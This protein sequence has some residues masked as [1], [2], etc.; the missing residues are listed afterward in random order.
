[1]YVLG[2][3]RVHADSSINTEH[4]VEVSQ[5]SFSLRR[6]QRAGQSRTEFSIRRVEWHKVERVSHGVQYS[7]EY[8]FHM[9]VLC[10]E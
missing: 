10:T 4:S 8:M 1:M 5:G 7:T 3:Y 2:M 9:C 6:R